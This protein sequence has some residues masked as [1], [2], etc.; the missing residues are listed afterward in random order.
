[1]VNTL[2]APTLVAA[3]TGV[4]QSRSV[5]GLVCYDEARILPAA[6]V[7]EALRLP[8][9][10]VDSVRRCRD[11]LATRQALARAG[12]AQPRALEAASLDETRAAAA[13]IG[14][15]VVLKPRGLGA[16]QGVVVVQGPDELS[17]AYEATTGAFYAGVPT[18]RSI[19]VEECVDGPE[20]SIDG[21]VAD[22]T[23][24]I[25]FLARKQLGLE[26]FFEE[27]GH[28]VDAAD[29]LLGSR[30]LRWV[31][32]ATHRALGIDCGLT[33]S[34]VRLTASGPRLIEVNGR[35]GGDLIPFLGLH[36]TGVDP[37]TVAASVATGAC[38]SVR[39]ARRGCVGI[40]FCYPPE[41]CRVTSIRVPAPD[42]S[43]GLIASAA[44][45]AAGS[46]VRLPPRGYAERYAHVICSGPDRES[47]STRL[48]AAATRVELLC[49]P[50]VDGEMAPAGHIAG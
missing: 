2:D 5:A 14:Y 13:D 3:A 31:L 35:L 47:C 37:G 7:V 50:L 28:M 22:G 48:D 24:R 39:P 27:T 26:P 33:H 25:L 17:D 19:L 43:T 6:H 18:Y 30:Q 11:K 12:V 36:A 10:G 38:P 8:G 42:A 1:V 16:S 44:I 29:P 4:A 20:I 15:P 9:M 46:C 41:D 40:R 23:Y 34:E 21:Y 45:A 32:E 49:E